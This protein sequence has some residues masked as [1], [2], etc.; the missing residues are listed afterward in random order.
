[1]RSRA[2]RGSHVARRASG[3]RCSAQVMRNSN[4]LDLKGIL[5]QRSARAIAA[6]LEQAALASHRRKAERRAAG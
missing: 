1:M 3:A 5:K 4:A 6:A 2:V